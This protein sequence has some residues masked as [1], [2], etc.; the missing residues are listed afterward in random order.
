MGGGGFTTPLYVYKITMIIYA[1]ES[2]T[3][4][5]ILSIWDT[6]Q[7]NEFNLCFDFAII[8]LFFGIIGYKL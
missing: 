7:I 2:H 8:N 3:K 5:I 1:D 6:I 4:T